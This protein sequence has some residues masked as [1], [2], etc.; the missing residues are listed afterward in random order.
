MVHAH[1]STIT[2]VHCTTYKHERGKEKTTQ[3]TTST[4]AQFVLATSTFYP[5][6]ISCV[7]IADT[8]ATL[9]SC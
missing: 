6:V 5:G 7:T 3:P 4:H 8:E 9:L 2:Y 1:V